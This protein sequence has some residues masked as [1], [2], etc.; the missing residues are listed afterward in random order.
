MAVYSSPSQGMLQFALFVA[1]V[2][3]ISKK[4]VAFIEK[5]HLLTLAT[6]KDNIPYCASCFFAFIEAS[7]TFVFATDEHTRHGQEALANPHVAGTVALET[8]ILGKVQGIQFTGLFRE[9]GGEESKVYFKKFPYALAMNPKLWSIEI[10]TI[11]FTDNTMGFGRKIEY[12]R[13]S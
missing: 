5:H 7:P 4:I 9:A 3:M 6:S 1:E 10:E 13:G 11:K 2:L 8:N 12:K